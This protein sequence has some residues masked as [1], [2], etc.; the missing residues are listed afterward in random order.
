MLALS[1][2][3]IWPVRIAFFDFAFLIIG[4]MFLMNLVKIKTNTVASLK[5]TKAWEI[6][7]ITVNTNTSTLVNS[8]QPHLYPNGT[9][10]SGI[11]VGL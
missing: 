8:D 6:K 2:L 10:R 7:E 4:Y 1:H 11:D 3:K 5:D 9:G